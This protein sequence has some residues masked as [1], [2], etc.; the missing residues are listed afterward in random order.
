MQYFD[1]DTNETL[2]DAMLSLATE[3]HRLNI[4]RPEVNNAAV[5]ILQGTFC[6]V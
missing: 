6:L 1:T 3:F 4:E 2:G 5:I